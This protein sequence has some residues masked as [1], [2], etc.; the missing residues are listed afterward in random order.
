MLC[1]ELSAAK[2][3][4]GLNQTKKAIKNGAA[5]KVFVASDADELLAR[6]VLPMCAEAAV[7]VERSLNME[8]LGRSCGIA[9][10]CGV[11]AVVA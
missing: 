5:T 6:Q 8:Q 7:P 9:V 11:C 4:V 10:K 3:V 2:K 1:E